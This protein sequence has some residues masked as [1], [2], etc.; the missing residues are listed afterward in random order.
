M[1]CDLRERT[2]DIVSDILE[3]AGYDVE[4]TDESF[5]LSAIG[6]D[7]SYIVLIS[8]DEDEI[9]RFDGRTFRLR[10]G[11]ESEVCGKIVVTFRRVSGL[12]SMLW[13]RED[14]ARFAGQAALARIFGHRMALEATASPT[15]TVEG[16]GTRGA[17]PMSR[18]GIPILHLPIQ[19]TDNNAQI[20]A[21][22]RGT[23]RCRFVPYWC[24]HCTST[25]SETVGNHRVSFEADI[26]G[27]LNAI[28]GSTMEMQLSDATD[29]P[30]PEDAGVLTPK[31]TKEKASASLLNEMIE[32]LTQRVR[33]KREEGDTVYYQVETLKPDPA[34]ITIDLNLVYVPVWEIESR[35]K[36]VEVNAFTGEI[37]AMPMDEGV[38]IF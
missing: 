17:A 37:L 15:I 29:I 18:G 20:I 25:G 13:G 35:D 8:D 38:E 26:S 11:D 7:D 31:T 34:N 4:C 12:S 10:R 21:G 5:D 14:I 30:M 23:V 2:Q 16:R 32:T 1:E 36:I 22:K 6:D 33:I 9:R 19:I 3:A 27:G 24:Y 28:N